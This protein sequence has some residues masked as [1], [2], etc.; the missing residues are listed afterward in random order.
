MTATH[1]MRTMTTLGAWSWQ[2]MYSA[3][4]PSQVPEGYAFDNMFYDW[5][6]S[7]RVRIP[8]SAGHKQWPV[9]R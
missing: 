1:G 3:G 7:E 9:A 4:P 8:Y 2:L 5:N 6:I